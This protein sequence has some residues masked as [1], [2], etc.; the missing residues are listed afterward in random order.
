[1]GGLEGMEKIKLLKKKYF[2]LFFIGVMLMFS[3]SI[4]QTSSAITVQSS[5]NVSVNTTG[6][7]ANT[8]QHHLIPIKPLVQ[9][10]NR[11]SNS[12]TVKF[13]EWNLQFI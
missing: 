13:V 4:L 1:M 3:M 5:S 2:F 8:W 12:G 6:N 10:I 9:G 11:V 7:D